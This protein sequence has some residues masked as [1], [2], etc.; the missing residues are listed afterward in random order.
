VRLGEHKISTDIDCDFDNVCQ[1]PVQDI[2][3]ETATK[4]P[5]YS[6]FKKTN[7]I[8][9]IRLKTAADVTKRN[10]K[11]ICLPTSANNQIGVIDEKIREKMVITGWGKI[12]SGK[13]SDVLMRAY[14]PFVKNEECSNRFADAGLPIYETYLCAGGKNKTDVNCVNIFND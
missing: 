12:E 8:A 5:N 9:I 13:A 10:V 2:A 7:D 1:D 6:N 11:T 3:I 4:H 14:V